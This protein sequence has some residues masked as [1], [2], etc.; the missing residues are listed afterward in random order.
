V[1]AVDVL[2]FAED[3]TG[4]AVQAARA[5]AHVDLA[6]TARAVAHAFEFNAQNGAL[7]ALCALSILL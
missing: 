6:E 7:R 2:H 3:A 5:V 1:D 4:E